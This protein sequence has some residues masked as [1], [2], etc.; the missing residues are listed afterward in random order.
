M[1]GEPLNSIKPAFSM[2]GSRL[3]EPT[4][5]APLNIPVNVTV[6][7]TQIDFVSPNVA[8]S[9]AS[10]EV[11]IHGDRLDAGGGCTVRRARSDTVRALW[12]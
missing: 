4:T 12:M 9:G 8:V 2:P 11:I 3:S 7:R 5:G 1:T 6:D 10:R